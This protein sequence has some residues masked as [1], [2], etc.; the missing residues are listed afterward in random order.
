[1]RLVGA[2]LFVGLWKL[3]NLNF[4]IGCSVFSIGYSCGRMGH[5]MS[6]CM[7]TRN[8]SYKIDDLIVKAK[9]ENFLSIR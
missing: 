9:M 5:T 3:L 1:V 2:F 7:V 6:I 4:E 8:L